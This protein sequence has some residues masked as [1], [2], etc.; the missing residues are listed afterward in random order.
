M[1]ARIS[2]QAEGGLNDGQDWD[3]FPTTLTPD[4]VA[5]MLSLTKETVVA[6]LKAG[7]IPAS[8]MGGSWIIFKAEILALVESRSGQQATSE[9]VDVLAGYANEMTYRDLIKLFGKTKLTIYRWLQTG[10]I[11]AFHIGDHWVIHTHQVRRAIHQASNQRV[12]EDR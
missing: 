7:T 4:H 10:V 2:A 12:L 1:Q 6:Q 3:S 5:Q 9:P 11:P 8:F